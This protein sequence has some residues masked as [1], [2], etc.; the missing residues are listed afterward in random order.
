MLSVR[1]G[2]DNS[3]SMSGTPLTRTPGKALALAAAI[4]V[5]AV[6]AASAAPGP[7]RQGKLSSLYV[8]T[9]A[10]GEIDQIK[11]RGVTRLT[12]FDPHGDVTA[13]TDRPARRAGH[14]KL[15]SFISG[16]NRL[17]FREVPPNAAL[18][19]ADAPSSR[20]VLVV[21][22]SKPRLGPGGDSVS[23]RAR[24]VKGSPTDALSRFRKRVDR[25]VADEFGEVS[26][27]I[28][29]SGEPV[30]LN[31]ELSNLP[32]AQPFVVGFTNTELAH[33]TFATR[34]RSNG[35][36]DGILNVNGL[37]VAAVGSVA[38]NASAQS[39]A[40]VAGGA[41]RVTGT[42]ESLPTGSSATLQVS[43][44]S[45]TGPTVPL[46]PGRFSVPLP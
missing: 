31:F 4:A 10:R 14:Q 30:S 33:G 44:D 35:P 3:G 24:L 37:V 9:A 21:E 32:P 7:K 43:D 23:F 39:G 22:L 1:H 45:G 13:F 38:V 18:L 25:R 28:D 26:L 42:V 29:P 16:W 8:M 17:G 19:L 34:V 36:V 27:F 40:E 11:G 12:L 2:I 41:T 46:A 15:A 20:D 5:V 6:A